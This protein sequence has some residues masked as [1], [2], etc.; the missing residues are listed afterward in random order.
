[1]ADPENNKGFIDSVSLALTQCP[2]E[3]FLAV[4]KAMQG[5]VRE[6]TRKMPREA[7]AAPRE[8]LT[9][10]NRQRRPR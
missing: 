8:P 10:H 7:R 5:E 6:G 2:E 4:E 9:T 3:T 1:M